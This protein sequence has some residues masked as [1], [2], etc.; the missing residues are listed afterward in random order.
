M[1]FSLF[2]Y[3]TG[4]V[5]LPSSNYASRNVSRGQIKQGG[6]VPASDAMEVA[7][8]LGDL[9]DLTVEAEAGPLSVDVSSNRFPQNSLYCF[10][11]CY[12]SSGSE[13]CHLPGVSR[14]M[15]S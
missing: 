10:C 8:R 2:F 9:A 4:D 12:L 5:V 11:C 7:L 3:L 1:L 13:N 15:Q 6:N 14:S